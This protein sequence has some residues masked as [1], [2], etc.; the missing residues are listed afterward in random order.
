MI[1]LKGL[2]KPNITFIGSSSNSHRG[3]QKINPSCLHM[4]GPRL[5]S[6]FGDRFF[7]TSRSILHSKTKKVIMRRSIPKRY[8]PDLSQT[9]SQR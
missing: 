9:S 1:V 3:P 2:T 6:L 8:R 4:T 5:L 7:D